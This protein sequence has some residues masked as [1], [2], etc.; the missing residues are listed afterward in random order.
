M[1]AY[2]HWSVDAFVHSTLT[3]IN[4]NLLNGYKHLMCIE[5]LLR[6]ILNS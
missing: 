4:E 3:E 5:K 6:L 2:S 1:Q